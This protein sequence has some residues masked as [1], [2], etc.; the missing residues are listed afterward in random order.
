[1]SI[2]NKILEFLVKEEEELT[3]KQISEKLDIKTDN[4]WIGLNTLYN[5]KKVKRSGSKKPYV[6]KA[7][8]P[9]AYLRRLYNFMSKMSLGDY[10]PNGEE[11][12]LVEQIKELIK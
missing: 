4:I 7:I 8:T 6:Y 1:M 11:M 9:E 5:E 12:K 10:I 3:S 2:K